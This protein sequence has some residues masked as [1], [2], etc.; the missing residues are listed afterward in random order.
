MITSGVPGPR[1]GRARHARDADSQAAIDQAIED[2]QRRRPAHAHGSG[3]VDAAGGDA[4]RCHDVQHLRLPGLEIPRPAA[5]LGEVGGG[6]GLGL[7]P[8]EPGLHL[9]VG[10]LPARRVRQFTP[11][12]RTPHAGAV[13]AEVRQT[14]EATTAAPHRG[15]PATLPAVTLADGS[16]LEGGAAVPAGNRRQSLG[17]EATGDRAEQPLVLLSR[18]VKLK[19]PFAVPTRPR[20]VDQ[21]V[22]PLAGEGAEL[23]AGLVCRPRIL[24]AAPLAPAGLARRLP[25]RPRAEAGG[26]IPAPGAGVKHL[27]AALARAGRYG[28][29]RGVVAALGAEAVA[30]R[31]R[32]PP[33]REFCAAPATDSGGKLPHIDV[34]RGRLERAIIPAMDQ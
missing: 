17:G 28:P 1:H 33:L 7:V 8:P 14:V 15:V 16:R 24:L 30:A 4:E 11:L 20:L 23:A 26:S 27:A 22:G 21:P 34:C 29:L 12:D 2:G 6:P 25:A 10:N 9:R 5:A 32:A 3:Q 13:A 19:L 18:L 31:V